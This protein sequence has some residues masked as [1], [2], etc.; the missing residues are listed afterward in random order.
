[1]TSEKSGSCRPTIA[2]SARVVVCASLPEHRR[3]QA[4]ERRDRNAERSERDRRGVGDERQRRG[5]DRLEAEAGEHRGGDRDRRA[6]AGDALDQRAETERDQ[7]DLDAPIA[8][9]PRQRCGG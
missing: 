1:M 4:A 5:H 7:H 9:Q 3:Q 2:D 6:E 8:G